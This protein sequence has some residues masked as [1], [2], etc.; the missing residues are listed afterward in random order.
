MKA[1]NGRSMHTPTPDPMEDDE[2]PDVK[3]PP[4]PPDEEPEVV[5]QRE[6]P[7]P[8]GPRPLRA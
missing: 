2:E 5:P 1:Q 7:Q 6:P 8:D 4:V 3:Q